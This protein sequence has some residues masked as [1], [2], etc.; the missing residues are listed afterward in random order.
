MDWSAT[1]SE[2]AA[3]RRAASTTFAPARMPRSATPRPIPDDAPTTTSDRRARAVV[4]IW[5]WP[6]LE[7][8]DAGGVAGHDEVSLVSADRLEVLLDNLPRVSTHIVDTMSKVS[9]VL[10]T[11][12]GARELPS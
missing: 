3:A 5:E 1:S 11:D 8:V 6:S 4:L 10:W 2:S 9:W 12:K 7:S